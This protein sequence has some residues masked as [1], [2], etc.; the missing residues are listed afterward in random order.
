MI[1]GFKISFILLLFSNGLYSQVDS[2]KSQIL[3]YDDSKS[4]IISKG[5]K[6]LLDKFIQKDLKTVDEIKDY[7]IEIED[8][9]YFAFFPEEYWFIL[10]WTKDYTELAN[11]IQ[12]F[13]SAKL[14]SYNT[15]IR[16]LNDMLYEK[17]KEKTLNNEI[18]I[19][20]QIEDSEI[21]PETKQVLSMILDW[22]LLEDRKTIYA[23]DSINKRAD[24]FLETYAQSEF[25]SFT[26]HYIR[27]KLIP[28]NW[29][30]TFEFFSGYSVY[31]GNLS[32]NYTNNVPIG[33]AFD[34]CYK[35]F[36]LYLRDYIGFNKTKKD[37]DYSLGTWEKGSR[38]TVFL[39]EASLG[40]VT[41]NDNRFKLSPF[42]GIGS[43]NISPTTK[44]TEQTP[45]LE[46]VSLDFTTTYILGINFD[47]KFGPKHT[48]DYSPKA[49][50]G[51]IRIRYGYSMPQFDKKYD[52][53]T[54]NMHYITIGFG[55]MGRG[56]K[57]DY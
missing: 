52:G 19:Q 29:G 34:I 26:R 51:F 1:K 17:L 18:L 4:S 5:R 9:D 20:K 49:S 41:Y 54:G 35:N 7:L 31:T 15:R 30:M 32:E 39:P 53:M 45:E 12:Q 27:Y 21:N 11:N 42:A 43:M 13:D 56:L 24:N 6:L 10:Y 40:Y 23:Q 16:P 55:G 36:E 2:I 22:L 44:D 3:D 46:E 33:V 47:I 48:P 50:Y 28:G 25:E 37:F 57:R 14:V 38:T 8:N